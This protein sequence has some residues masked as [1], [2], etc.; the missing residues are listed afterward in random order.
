[1]PGHTLFVMLGEA[2]PAAL[3]QG[4]ALARAAAERYRPHVQAWVVT[5]NAVP[6]RG[7]ADELLCD[8]TGALHDRF[9]ADQASLC[10]VRPD[11]HLGLHA[12]PPSLEEL[13][14]HLGRILLPR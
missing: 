2:D 9:G 11:G 13:Q 12:A 4:L 14:A 3:E 7:A 6:G 10:L 5:R 1:M 8:P